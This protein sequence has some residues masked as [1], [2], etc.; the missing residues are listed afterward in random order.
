MSV[1]RLGNNTGFP[2]V[3]VTTTIGVVAI[4]GDLS[5]QRLLN[6]YSKGIFPWYSEGGPI[7]WWSPDPRLVLFTD[8][9]HISKSMK[10]LINKNTFE[11]TFDSRFAEVIHQCR[12]P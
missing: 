8:E 10:R 12:L 1:V 9:L 6:A 7:L 11:V 5:S 2:P 3:K 4:G